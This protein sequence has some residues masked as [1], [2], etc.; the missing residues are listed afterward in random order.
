[1]RISINML[2]LLSMLSSFTKAVDSLQLIKSISCNASF[3]TTDPIGNIYAICNQ[4]SV[5]KYNVVGDS[6]AIF[7]ELRKGKVSHIDATNPLRILVNYTSS[8]QL[9]LLD[10]M[11]SIKSVL[12]IGQMGLQNVRCVATSADGKIWMYDPLDAR[13]IKIDDKLNIQFS[14]SMRNVLQQPIDPIWMVEHG[15]NLYMLDSTQG[16]FKFDLF[17]FYNTTYPFQTKEMQCFKENIVYTKGNQLF[18]YNTQTL[19]EKHILLPLD[20]AHTLQVRVERNKVYIRTSSRI[21][22]YQLD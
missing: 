18:S 9:I 11:L 5:I 8:G 2:V 20:E 12:K 1:M 15:R 19:H 14:S 22:I 6:I 17:G 21:N 7:N 13:L 10:N 16:I 3:F 4:N